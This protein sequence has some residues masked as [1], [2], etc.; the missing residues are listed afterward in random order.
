MRPT[1]ATSAPTSD[2]RMN[3]FLDE[4]FV[5]ITR[6]AQAPAQHG[7]D[8]SLKLEVLCRCLRE[9]VAP[10]NRGDVL[11]LLLAEEI[12]GDHTALQ[13]RNSDPCSSGG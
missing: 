10:E 7:K 11:T 13:Q 12:R 4:L 6:L 9:N 5:V 8:L 3:A 2:E 1:V